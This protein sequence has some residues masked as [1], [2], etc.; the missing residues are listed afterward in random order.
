MHGGRDARLG[1]T[2]VEVQEAR[3]LARIQE[4]HTVTLGVDPVP[5]ETSKTS[6]TGTHTMDRPPLAPDTL[7]TRLYVK[8]NHKR[9]HHY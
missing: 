9:V 8:L 5:A 2:I 3:P 4:R 7:H 1:G 6:T